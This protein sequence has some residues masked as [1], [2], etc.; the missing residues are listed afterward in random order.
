VS[1]A[2]G[3]AVGGVLNAELV[4]EGPAFFPA[5]IGFICR[6]EGGIEEL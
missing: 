2:E 5:T 6:S 3:G 1:L 4:N